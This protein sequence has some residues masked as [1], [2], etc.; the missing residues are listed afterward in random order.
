MG[1]KSGILLKS[2]IGPLSDFNKEYYIMG[3]KSAHLKKSDFQ[4]SGEVDRFF[5]NG[6]QFPR[7]IELS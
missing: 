2:E 1:T 5:E 6:H 4:E 3:L 7:E